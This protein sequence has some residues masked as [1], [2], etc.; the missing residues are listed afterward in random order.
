MVRPGNVS[1]LG[2]PSLGVEA[3]HGRSAETG[4]PTKGVPHAAHLAGLGRR[5]ADHE[6]GPHR[7]SAAQTDPDLQIRSAKPISD[8]TL[9]ATAR[10]SVSAAFNSLGRAS[11]V[12][13]DE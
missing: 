13:G 10:G 4:G 9:L 8:V 2:A 5:R 3:A 7:K 1:A 12:D 11:S 6:Q